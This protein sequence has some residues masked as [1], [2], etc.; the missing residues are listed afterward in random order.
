MIPTNGKMGDMTAAATKTKLK[1]ILPLRSLYLQEMNAQ[2]RYNACHERGHSDSYVL[3]IDGAE[4]G[5]G[6]VKGRD[7]PARDAVF[8]FFVIQPFRK[9]AGLLFREL[10]AA[11]GA[12]QV[13]CQSNDALLTSLLF[14]HGSSIAADTILFADHAV[15]G[16]A[17]PGIVVRER[18]KRDLVFA[19]K[20]EPVG[21]YVA[22]LDG[23]IVATGGF[24][25][26][27]NMPFADLFMEVKEDRRLRGIASLLLQEVKKACYLAGRVPAARCDL[28]NTGSKAS[29]LKAGMRVAGFMLTGKVTSQPSE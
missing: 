19:H 7:G 17:V 3:T 12:C 15:T 29:L 25:C 26:H 1:S 13:E 20:V 10:F 8:E 16:L 4:A 14:E 22:V 27:Y 24:L 11:S 5:Y 21:D 2:I 9:H 18:K 6:S 28:R 23:E